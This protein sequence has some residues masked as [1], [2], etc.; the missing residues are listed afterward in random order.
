MQVY[1]LFEDVP[2]IKGD[3]PM[4]S[5]FNAVNG[6]ELDR[7][8]RGVSRVVRL[9]GTPEEAAAF[10]FI[11]AEFTSW[12]YQ[13]NR[14]ASDA[15]IGYPQTASL[16]LLGETPV[17]IHANGY[18]LSPSTGPGGVTGELVYVGK[19][20]ASDYYGKDLR[21]KIAISEGL[22]MPAKEMAAAAAGAIGQ[23]HI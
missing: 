16:T 22:A 23:I 18:S 11:E 17:D 4:T 19:G 3:D 8:L 10:D 13:V 15:L 1:G 5:L 2:A 12:G 14:Y 7:F 21:G 9:S 20:A 6:A